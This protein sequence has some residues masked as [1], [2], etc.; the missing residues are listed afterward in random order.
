VCLSLLYPT[1]V[2][3]YSLHSDSQVGGPLLV[4]V[5]FVLG[6]IFLDYTLLDIV[7]WTFWLW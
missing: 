2:L 5:H 1:V 7:I 4:V 3:H 6:S